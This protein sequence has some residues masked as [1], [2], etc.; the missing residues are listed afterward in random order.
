[1][2]YFALSHGRLQHIHKKLKIESNIFTS[3]VESR[4]HACMMIYLKFDEE[5]YKS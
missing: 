4:S 2:Y 1:M 5:K 3:F